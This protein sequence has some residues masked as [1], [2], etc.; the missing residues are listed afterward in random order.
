MKT[1]PKTQMIW[2]WE[3]YKNNFKSI[4]SSSCSPPATRRWYQF[5]SLPS[6]WFQVVTNVIFSCGSILA[7]VQVTVIELYRD[8]NWKHSE[9]LERVN[10]T[11]PGGC[12]VWQVALGCLTQMNWN[13][14]PHAKED[15]ALH[16]SC[17]CEGKCLLGVCFPMRR[18]LL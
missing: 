7:F 15:K 8:S 12:G 6:A 3:I 16:I 10:A 13:S 1:S 9:E 17:L 11:F 5:L 18:I 2:T 4:S 14:A